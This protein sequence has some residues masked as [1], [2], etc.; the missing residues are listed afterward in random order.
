MRVDAENFLNDDHAGAI[1]AGRESAISA[2]FLT[3][4]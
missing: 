2:E 3:F 1:A 4:K